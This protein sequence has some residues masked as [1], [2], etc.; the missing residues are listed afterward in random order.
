MGACLLQRVVQHRHKHS[1]NTICA[2]YTANFERLRPACVFHRLEFNK[3]EKQTKLKN[4][5]AR[6]TV[7]GTKTLLNNNA[8]HLCQL[9]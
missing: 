6:T 5:G 3:K 2:K 9:V 4:K 7:H 1:Q 8:S